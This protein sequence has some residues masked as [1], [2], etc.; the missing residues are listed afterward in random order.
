MSSRPDLLARVREKHTLVPSVHSLRNEVRE[1][2]R[3]AVFDIPSNAAPPE[4]TSLIDATAKDAKTDAT[5]ANNRLDDIQSAR[6]VSG[7]KGG[8]VAL[9]SLL[10]ALVA[11]GIITDSTTA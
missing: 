9:A 8:N 7:A 6:D 1:L 3:K 4:T 5:R 11:A 10:S 2:Q